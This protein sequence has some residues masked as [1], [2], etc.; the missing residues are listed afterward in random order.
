MLLTRVSLSCSEGM[1]CEV[2]YLISLTVT[3]LRGR[4]AVIPAS[5]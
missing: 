4:V 2:N 1:I 3:A 5:Y